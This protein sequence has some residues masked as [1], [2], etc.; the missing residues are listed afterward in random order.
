MAH[1]HDLIEGLQKNREVSIDQK[2]DLVFEILTD[3]SDAI[4]KNFEKSAKKRI[5]KQDYI[6]IIQNIS[7]ILPSL[8]LSVPFFSTLTHMYSLRPL[9]N[10]LEKE[11]IGNRPDK[12]KTIIWFTDTI[13]DLNGVS[14]TL[15]KIGWFCQKTDRQLKIV[16]FLKEEELSDELPP[17]FVNVPIVYDFDMPFYETIR[18]KVPSLLK[19][20]EM[21]YQYEPDEIYISTPG[22]IG[23]LGLLFAKLINVPVTGIYHTDFT[24]QS[25]QIVKNDTLSEMIENATRWFFPVWTILQCRQNSISIY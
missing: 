9:L 12:K 23:L 17:D 6:G 14:V 16:S 22:P 3:I 2:F 19:A 13:N 20:V 5:K 8:F 1:L 4:M 7:S 18:F 21:L 15:K 11:F 10:Y 24:E 25:R